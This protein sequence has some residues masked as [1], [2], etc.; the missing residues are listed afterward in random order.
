MTLNDLSDT[1]KDTKHRAV[2]A[3][4]ELLVLTD[5]KAIFLGIMFST[6]LFDH[7]FAR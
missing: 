1:A 4:A 7:P 5:R 3:T 2:S 6:C